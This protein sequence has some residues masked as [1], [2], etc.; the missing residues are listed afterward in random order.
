MGAVSKRQL[1]G[2]VA[3]LAGSPY[4]SGERSFDRV[5]WRANRGQEFVLGGYIPNGYAL[6]SL[7]VGYYRGL[8]YA[9]SVRAGIP[10]EFRRVLP[11]HLEQLRTP[12]YAFV[13]LPDRDE[14]RWGEGSFA[15]KMATRCWLYPFTAGRNRVF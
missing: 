14:G 9:A 15:T 7:V 3:K 4:R 10:M 13:L 12:R 11:A 6:D 5:K 8:L 1:E 2:M